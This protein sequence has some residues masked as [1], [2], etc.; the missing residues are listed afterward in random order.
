MSKSKDTPSVFYQHKFGR[1]FPVPLMAFEMYSVTVCGAQ[2]DMEVYDVLIK[3]LTKACNIKSQSDPELEKDI[4]YLIER[5]TDVGKELNISQEKSDNVIT[6]SK[7]FGTSYM[8]YLH[9]LS[10]DSAILRMVTYDIE[11]ANRLYCELDRDEVM[12]LIAE[13]FSGKAEENLVK[14]EASMYGNGGKYQ[15]DKG[16]N[17]EKNKGKMHD[18]S[19]AAG[20]ANLKSMGF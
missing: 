2:T 8:E 7:S 1:R 11:A 3:V 10:V 13:Y 9:D 20:F 5:I 16:G 14:M 17:A 18:I 4:A 19:T 12:V 6:P 15:A